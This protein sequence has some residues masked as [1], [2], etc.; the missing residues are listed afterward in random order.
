[1]RNHR[2]KRPIESNGEAEE[3]EGRIGM[4][5][6]MAKKEKKTAKENQEKIEKAAKIENK[7]ET[8][9]GNKTEKIERGSA[10][11]PLIVKLV[12]LA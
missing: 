4:L 7:G 5:W 10:L 12:S 11:N 3:G 8:E 1:M 9:E 6:K 2:I